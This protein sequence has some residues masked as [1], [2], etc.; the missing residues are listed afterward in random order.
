M[1]YKEYLENFIVKILDILPTLT[2]LPHFDMLHNIN[3]TKDLYYQI[4]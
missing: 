1:K 2:Y 4:L 3:Q